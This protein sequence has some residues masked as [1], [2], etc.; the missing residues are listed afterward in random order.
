MTCPGQD[1]V[2]THILELPADAEM[3]SLQMR[4]GYK[5]ITPEFFLENYERMDNKVIF[6]NNLDK[7][8]SLFQLVLFLQIIS[9]Q[10]T[11]DKKIKKKK[12]EIEKTLRKKLKEFLKCEVE[13]NGG[14]GAHNIKPHITVTAFAAWSFLEINKLGS[15]VDSKVID[16]CFDFIRVENSS[17][18]QRRID[19]FNFSRRDETSFFSNVYYL[20]LFSHFRDY[21]VRADAVLENA[22]EQYAKIKDEQSYPYLEAFVAMALYG[23]AY[24]YSNEFINCYDI[25]KVNL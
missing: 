23:N 14:F 15:F 16:R 7:L 11:S 5:S 2:K 4:V 3:G 21:N 18:L 22:L 9:K 25:H 20:F 17:F 19:I 13:V 8:S 6:G 12:F 1:Y 24:F 10:D